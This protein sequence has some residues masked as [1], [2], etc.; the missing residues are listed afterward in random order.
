MSVRSRGRPVCSRKEFQKQILKP[1]RVYVLE[2]T[3]SSLPFQGHYWPGFLSDTEHT[4]EE[5]LLNASYLAHILCLSFKTFKAF[6]EH[7][8]SNINHPLYL[9]DDKSLDNSQIR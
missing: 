5:P 1:G 7:K 9:K 4:I 2:A 3:A 8:W 6:C